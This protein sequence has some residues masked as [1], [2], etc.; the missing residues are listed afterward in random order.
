M[1]IRQR[2]S[3]TALMSERRGGLEGETGRKLQTRLFPGTISRRE[4]GKLTPVPPMMSLSTRRARVSGE[5]H[6]A[7]NLYH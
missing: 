1:V 4:P 2:Q 7:L 3:A 5:P 6:V